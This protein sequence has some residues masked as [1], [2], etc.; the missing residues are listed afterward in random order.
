M[1][2]QRIARLEKENKMLKMRMMHKEG[3]SPHQKMM[4]EKMKKIRE[5]KKD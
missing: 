1:Q 3:P 2:S 4:I 5:D